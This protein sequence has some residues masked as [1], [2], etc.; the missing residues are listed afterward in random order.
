MVISPSVVV[1]SAVVVTLSVVVRSFTAVVVSPSLI[2]ASSIALICDVVPAPIVVIA[3]F[4]V[5]GNKQFQ[6]MC[7]VPQDYMKVNHTS[8]FLSSTKRYNNNN[9]IIINIIIQFIFENKRNAVTVT[10]K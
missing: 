10:C 2:V 5:P 4:D 3:G 8:Q 7:T 6:N 1:S 9:V